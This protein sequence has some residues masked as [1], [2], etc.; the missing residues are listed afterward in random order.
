MDSAHIRVELVDRVLGIVLDRPEKKNAI[1]EAMYLDMAAALRHAADEPGIRAVLLAGDGGHFSSGND[2]ADFLH[3]PDD[4][5]NSPVGRFMSALVNCPKPIVAA[6]NGL[7]IGIGTTLLM[8]CD[9][10]YAASDARFRMPFVHIG[11]CPEFGASL[12]LPA[13]MGHQRAA[14]LLLIADIFDAATA[15]EYGM[16]NAVLSPDTVRAHAYA[17]A[18]KLARQAP[19]A[20]RVSKALLKRWTREAVAEAIRV[21]GEQFVALLRQPEAAEAIDAFLHKRR[22]D[23]SRFS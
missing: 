5:P 19:N 2:I 16:V 11:G 15:R 4:I 7:A 20:L 21:E 18:L 12:M 17:Q 23:F 22:A 9:L 10:V 1:S 3:P 13:L 6:V 14:E 8:H